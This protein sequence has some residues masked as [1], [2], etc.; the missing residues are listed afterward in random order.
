MSRD[1][2]PNFFL[3]GA[4][5]CGTTS[6]YLYLKQHPAIYL[7]V[8]KEP[9]YYCRDLSAPSF[10]VTERADYQRLFSDV[11]TE[12]IV[13]EGSVWYLLSKVAARAIAADAPEA[14]ALVMLRRPVDMM[15]SLH[16]L[17]LRTG[18]EDLADFAEALAAEPARAR[19]QRLPAGAYFP[20]GLQYTRVARYAEQLER[21]ID[22]LGRERVHCVLFDEFARDPAAAVR[23]TVRFLGLD[24]EVAIDIEPARARARVRARVLRQLRRIPPAL[25]AKL[26]LGDEH[27]GARRAPVSAALRAQ[28]A[29]ALAGDVARLGMLLGRDLSHWSRDAD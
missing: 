19:G 2:Q 14:R 16:A 15:A 18:N 11:G 5:R 13:G 29:R 21:F 10:A 20:E 6:M 23:D 3:V 1:V 4:P 17:Y 27:E 22:A 24:P 28:V 9:L 8:I 7:A 25:R 26:K 12:I